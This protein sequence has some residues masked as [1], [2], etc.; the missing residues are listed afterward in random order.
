MTVKIDLKRKRSPQYFPG[1]F[2]H[3]IKNYLAVASCAFSLR[4]ISR[5]IV[6]S[7]VM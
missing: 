5:Q 4:T 6:S 3:Y 7:I 2:L 1:D